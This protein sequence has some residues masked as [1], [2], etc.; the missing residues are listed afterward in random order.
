MVVMGSKGDANETHFVLGG[1]ICLCKAFFEGRRLFVL[2]WYFYGNFL[3][4][5]EHP[6]QFNRVLPPPS[7][8][9]KHLTK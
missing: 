9:F 5:R 7:P 6:S 1:S 8:H 4:S 2:Q 3:I